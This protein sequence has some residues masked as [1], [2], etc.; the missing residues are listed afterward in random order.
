MKTGQSHNFLIS[1]D[2]IQT[3]KAEMG[4]WIQCSTFIQ[5]E[6]Y[7]RK[8]SANYQTMLNIAQ[9]LVWDVNFDIM[10]H[11]FCLSARY[12]EQQIFNILQSQLGIEPS[13]SDDLLCSSA[14]ANMW[15]SPLRL[16]SNLSW[17]FSLSPTNTFQPCRI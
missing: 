16:F 2:Y 7:K 13:S 6:A 17:P 4:W 11:G 10:F 12:K 9:I 14:M 15:T 5:C 3:Q 1:E 8:S